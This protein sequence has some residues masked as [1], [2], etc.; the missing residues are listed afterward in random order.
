MDEK[1]FSKFN[2][3][4]RGLEPNSSLKNNQDYID[5]LIKIIKVNEIMSR[6]PELSLTDQEEYLPVAAPSPEDAFP[7]MSSPQSAGSRRREPPLSSI[8]EREGG[9]SSL[10]NDP[11]SARWLNLFNQ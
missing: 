9:G 7:S 3:V 8:P 6:H 2:E 10:S 1:L 4:L 11:L 5:Q